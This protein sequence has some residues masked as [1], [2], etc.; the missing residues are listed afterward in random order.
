MKQVMGRRKTGCS[1]GAVPVLILLSLIMLEFS[2]CKERFDPPTKNV[3][4]NFLVI[5]G[6]VNVGNEETNIRL[7]RTSGL[8]SD[9]L[10][11]ET[12]AQVRIEGDDNSSFVLPE[13]GNGDYGVSSIFLDTSKKYRL[14]INTSNGQQFVSDYVKMVKNPPI[15]SISWQRTADGLQIYTSTHDPLNNTRYYRWQY[16]ETWEHHAAY[17][18][19]LKYVYDEIQTFKIT[20]VTY[21]NQN[22]PQIYECWTRRFPSTIFLGSAEKLSQATIFLPIKFI[23]NGAEELSVKYYIH[24]KQFALS[25][26]GYQ[27]FERLKKNTESLGSIFDAQ[28]S[29]LTG[30]IKCV[31]NPEEPVVGFFS[32]SNLSEAHIFIKSTEANWFYDM[33]CQDF[34]IKNNQQELDDKAVGTLP[35]NVESLGPFA[36]ITSFRASAPQCVDCR[37]NGGT[38]IKPDFWH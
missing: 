14:A 19:Q 2:A 27:F 25:K 22:D 12:G 5:E 8:K 4:T 26:E 11:V 17:T 30:N 13:K 10:I 6:E 38:N 24:V 1:N 31:T 7:T 9:S 23:P 20:G 33:G 21:R 15:D 35:T 29:Q 18:S 34:V 37:L 28:P 16:D 36:S 32:L 3:N